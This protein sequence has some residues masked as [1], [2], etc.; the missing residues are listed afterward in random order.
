MG[1][2]SGQLRMMVVGLSELVSENHLL[3]Q[4][5][6]AIDSSF[7][8]QLINPLYA[9]KGRKSIDPVSFFK[10]LLV[11]YLFGIKLERRLV[12]EIQLNIA[13]RWF[14]NFDMIDK[15]PEHST[16]SK[17]RIRRWKES[18]LF[19][20][21]F[22]YIV[23][24]CIEGHLVDGEYT[25]ADGSYIP[26]SVSRSSWT[27]IKETVKKS[28]QSYLDVLDGELAKE[29]GFHAPPSKEVPK[30]RTTSTTDPECG[31]IHHGTKRGIGY[32]MEATVDCKNGIL[33]GVDVYSADQKESL[34]VLRHL[35]KQ[36]KYG[37][38]IK[39]IALDRGYDTGAVH[40]GLEL[41]GIL[42]YIA[43]SIF[44][45]HQRCT[46]F[47]MMKPG[48]SSFAQKVINYAIIV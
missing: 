30:T 6:R 41:L 1:Q 18:S 15:I 19:E 31:Y 42:G 21:I 26:A 48:I 35:E 25:A 7:I 32:L 4:I 28:M 10:M 38:K 47:D 33:T 40:R 13:Y 37:V 11:G 5:D 29:P 34:V 17:N 24:L 16:F 46:D 22:E 9:Q 23:K 44:P 3:K 8:Y 12:Q 36:Q 20:E 39:S 45:I 2:K 27:D 43:P 14:C